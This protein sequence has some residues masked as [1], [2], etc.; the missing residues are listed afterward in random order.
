LQLQQLFINLLGNS[1]KFSD[2]QPVITITGSIITPLERVA[3]PE[4]RD[5]I[6]YVKLEFIDNGIGFEPQFSEKIFT[7]FQ[8]LN[9]RR[10]YDGT[11]IGLALCKKIVE[12]HH[13]VIRAVG[14]P[15]EGAIFTIILPQGVKDQ[16]LS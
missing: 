11:G 14:K 16:E 3:Y 8:R 1:L 7:I 6:T 9:E 12:N 4:L 10:L 15:N 5:D 2:K 13:G